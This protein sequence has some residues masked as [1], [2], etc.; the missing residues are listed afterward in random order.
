[1]TMWFADLS[2]TSPSPLLR[3]PNIDKRTEQLNSFSR[4]T[5]PVRSPS[6]MMYACAVVKTPRPETCRQ[7]VVVDQSGR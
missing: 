3:T 2:D 7:V 4:S 6:A 5:M 1:M